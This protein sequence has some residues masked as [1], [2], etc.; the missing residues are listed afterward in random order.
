MRNILYLIEDSLGKPLSLLFLHKYPE[1][2]HSL[3]CI[4]L[5]IPHL[6]SLPIPQQVTLEDPGADSYNDSVLAPESI[7]TDPSQ[8]IY[9]QYEFDGSGQT[10]RLTAYSASEASGWR[11]GDSRSASCKPPLVYTIAHTLQPLLNLQGVK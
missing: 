7:A 3:R 9:A 10:I 8:E 11:N 2:L 1:I 6:S 4:L 5:H